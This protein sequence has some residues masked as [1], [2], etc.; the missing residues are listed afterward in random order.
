MK[1][2]EDYGLHKYR[3]DFYS[4]CLTFK[5]ML[6]LRYQ[7]SQYLFFCGYIHSLRTTL[8]NISCLKFF[9]RNVEVRTI[10]K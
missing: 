5:H 10:V 2:K 3:H 7:I 9:Y 6:I 4:H 8:C 1:K